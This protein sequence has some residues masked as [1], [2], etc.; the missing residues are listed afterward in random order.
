MTIPRLSDVA[1]CKRGRDTR[2]RSREDDDRVVYNPLLSTTR[3]RRRCRRRLIDLI[4][5]RLGAGY[6]ADHRV[7][8]SEL[9]GAR[10]ANLVNL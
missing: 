1:V 3:V 6:T 5:S 2:C 8:A 9:P 7:K 4:T 10:F